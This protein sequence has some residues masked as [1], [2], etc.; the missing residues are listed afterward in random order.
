M[1]CQTV[2]PG[3]RDRLARLLGPLH[4][5]LD[6]QRIA[7]AKADRMQPLREL[8]R[9]VGAK[10]RHRARSGGRLDHHRIP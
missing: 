4:E 5:F 3:N 6:E 8:F 1:D 10:R 7:V 2:A 9:V